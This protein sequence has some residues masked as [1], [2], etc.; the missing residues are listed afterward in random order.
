[1]YISIMHLSVPEFWRF[2]QLFNAA[3]VVLGRIGEDGRIIREFTD[4]G[5]KAKDAAS[6][7]MDAEATLGDIPDEF[8]DPI[9]VRFDPLIVCLS[10]GSQSLFRVSDLSISL[11][12]ITEQKKLWMCASRING[13]DQT[14]YLKL[15][16]NE[17]DTYAADKPVKA[18]SFFL[19]STL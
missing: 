6:E 14:D 8:L 1:M 7:A 2:L 4:L 9:Q 16:K 5:N 13:F 18:L 12:M 15:K 3:A 10:R 19:C 11:C 17:T